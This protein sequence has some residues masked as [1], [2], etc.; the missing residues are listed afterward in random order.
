M[1]MIN[2]QRPHQNG[3]LKWA[4]PTTIQDEF[5]EIVDEVSVIQ[6]FILEEN[7][8]KG[9]LNLFLGKNTAP[10]LDIKIISS[11]ILLLFKE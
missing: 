8:F 9:K 2:L 11:F 10:N 1:T 5:G 4:I 7:I 6:E 3:R